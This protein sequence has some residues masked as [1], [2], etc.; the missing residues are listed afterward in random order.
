MG[1]AGCSLG[2]LPALE[3][4]KRE[5]NRLLRL[6]SAR[7][8][9]RLLE[10]IG[11]FSNCPKTKEAAGTLPA[12]A[13]TYDRT[14]VKQVTTVQTTSSAHGFTAVGAH[15]RAYEHKVPW[16]CAPGRGLSA[17]Y[18]SLHLLSGLGALCPS[19]RLLL[20]AWP[21]G[22]LRQP[23]SFLAGRWASRAETA[24]FRGVVHRPFGGQTGR[25]RR[26][27]LIWHKPRPLETRL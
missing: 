23:P 12:V 21:L 16:P 8:L 11:R 6:Q 18:H 10:A 14:D 2:A 26:R 7:K 19:S 22:C 1:R 13:R 27:A 24:I 20:D 15:K 4:P 3:S 17:A 9:S 25:P 5:R